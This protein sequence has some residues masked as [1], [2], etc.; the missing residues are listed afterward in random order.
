MEA[1]VQFFQTLQ[2]R[3]EDRVRDLGFSRQQ[4]R[5]L[6][7]SLTS[8]VESGGG[9]FA[10]DEWNPAVSPLIASDP[11]W[12]AVQ[13][14]NQ[15]RIVLPAGVTDLEQSADQFIQ[16]LRPEH[17]R[18]LDEILQDEVLAPLGDLQAACT[19]SNDLLRH[20][21]RPLV[22]Q[23]AVYLGTVLPITDVAQVEYSAAGAL[24]EAVADRLR[25]Y[26]DST[27]PTI[28]AA[29]SKGQR[30]YLLVPDSEAGQRLGEEARAAL[31]ALQLVPVGSPTELTFCREQDCLS[32]AVLLRHLEPAR[33][34]Y[35]ELAPVPAI[36]PHARFDVLEWLPLDV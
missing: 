28:G 18:R 26:C 17:W 16:S 8:A 35:H 23:A 27:V 5:N 7:K 15:V 4:L 22:E 24:N 31:P 33:V 3:L 9:T 30:A 11:F 12:D 25:V 2:G 13:D 29:D 21:G 34:A 10:S 32:L 14:S 36:S 6:Y 1:G 20:L 19:G